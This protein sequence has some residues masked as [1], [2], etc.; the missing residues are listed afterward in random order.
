MNDDMLRDLLRETADG[1][2]PATG[3]TPSG[4]RPP[5]VVVRRGGGG[6]PA[7]PAWWLRP[8]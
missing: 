1:S 2:R 3:W 6:S 4:L 7:V 8:W 5:A